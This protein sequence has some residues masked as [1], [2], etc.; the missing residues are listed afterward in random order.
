MVA[1]VSGNSLGLNVTSQATLGSQGLFGSAVGGR[2]NER[3]YVNIANGNLVLQDRDE[4]LLGRGPDADVL[5]TY[6]SEG[7]LLGDT[8]T[9]GATR[10]R[11]YTVA[12]VTGGLLGGLDG[13]TNPATPIVRVDEDGAEAIYAWDKERQLFLSTDGSGAYDTIVYDNVAKQFIWTDGAT[14]VQERY[15]G[16]LASL[17]GA[18]LQSVADTNG[19]V[20]RYFYNKNKLL[21]AILNG[22]LARVET[23]SG[24]NLYFDYND[25]GQITQIRKA[26][27]D[28]AGT[29]DLTKVRYTYDNWKRLSTV[30]VDLSPDDSSIADGRIYKT[31]YTYDGASSR[32]ASITQSDGTTVKFTYVVAGGA[33]RVASVTDGLGQ[34]T[35]Y[36]YDIRSRVTTVTDPLGIQTKYAYDTAGQLTSMTSPAAGGVSQAKHFEYNENGDLLRVTD[37]EGHV[38]LMEYDSWGNQIVQR[39]SLGNTVTRTYDGHHQ[40]LTETAYLVPDADGAG[41]E[42][43]PGMPMTTRYVYDGDGRNL[44]RFVMSPEGRVT[45][46]RYNAFGQRTATL[47]YD[48]AHYPIGSL[49]GLQVPTEAEMQ[50]WLGGIDLAQAIRADTTYDFRGQIDTLTTYVSLDAQGNGVVDAGLA[51]THYVYDHAGQLLQTIA[52]DGGVTYFVYDGLGR[53][54]ATTDAL[55]HVTVTQFDDANNKTVVTLVNG[56]AT[57]SSYDKAGRLVSVMQANPAGQALGITQYF[58]DADN[59]L[60]MSQDP[61]GVRHWKVYDEIGR[62]VGDVD[63]NGTLTETIYNKND[64]ITQTITY[65]TAVNVALLVNAQGVPQKVALA[66][67]RPATSTGDRKSWRAYDAANRLAKE[68]DVDGLLTEYHYDGASR[69]TETIR[70]ATAIDTSP[71]G[72]A[73]SAGSIVATATAQD[74]VARNFYDDDG[75]LRATLDAE[76]Y[77]VELRYDAAGKVVERIAYATATDPALRA[78]GTFEQLVPVG[79]ANDIH[80]HTLYNARGQISGEVDGESTLTEKIYDANGSLAQ[81]IQYANRV[82]SSAAQ[83]GISVAALRPAASAEDQVQYWNHD[84]LG[85]I[86]SYTDATGTRTAYSYDAVGNLTATT[87]AIGT[88]EVRTLTQR[89]DLQ[90]RLTGELSG[91]GSAL[92]NGGQTSA[93]IDVIWARHGMTHTYDAAGRRTGSTDANGN[94]TLFFYDVDGNLTHT[95]NALGEVEARQYNSFNQVTTTTRH[96]TRLA[97]SVLGTMTGGLLTPQAEQDFANLANAALDSTVTMTYHADG[98][99]ASTTDAAGHTI[100]H[101]YDIFNGEALR[102]ETIDGTGATLQISSTRDRRGLATAVTTTSNGAAPALPFVTRSEYDAFGRITRTVDAQGNVRLQQYDRTGRIVQTTDP[103]NGIRTTS[104]D[105]FGRVLTQTDA[106][107]NATQYRYDTSARSFTVTTAEGVAVTTVRNRHGQTASVTDGNGNTT[108]YRYDKNGNL[109]ATASPVSATASVYDGA[110]RLIESI[111]GNGN[112]IGYAYDAANRLLTRTVDPTG[113]ALVTH[114][115][116]DAKGQKIE[117][118]DPNGVVTQTEFDRGGRVLRQTVDPTGLALST[119]YTH[120]ERGNTLTVT[121]PGGTVTRHVYDDLG[122]RIEEH[123]DATGLD[124]I[125]RY[126]YDTLGNLVGAIDAAGNLTRYAYDADNRLIFTV[127]AL[128]QVQQNVYD[129]EG[130]IVRTT[131]YA[132]ALD[133]AALPSAPS[134]AEIQSRLATS[135]NDAVEYRVLDRDGRLQYSVDGMGGVAQYRYDGAG[136]LTERIGYANWINLS[137]WTPGTTP[138]PITDAAR[139]LHERTVYDG[140]NRAIYTVD[141][142]GSVVRQRYDGNGNVVE[143]IAYAHAIPQGTPATAAGFDAATASIA[144]G[145]RDAHIRR[146]YDAANRLTWSM[147]GAGSVTQQVYDRNGNILKQIAYATAVGQNATPDSAVASAG[148]RVTETVY[149][150]VNRAIF[151]IDAQGGVSRTAFDN[152][153]NVL[154]R[155]AYSTP[156]DVPT[157]ASAPRSLNG[158]MSSV[159]ASDDDRVVY[160][161][162]DSASRPTFKI[163]NGNVTET[164]YDAL[165]NALTTIAYS[166]PVTLA[167]T[168]GGVGAPSVDTV[169]AGLQPDPANDRMVQRLFDANSRQTMSVDPLGVATQTRYDGIG[170]VVASTTYANPL[171]AG[172]AP[173]ATAI[174]GALQADPAQDRTNTFAYDAASRLISST[175]ALGYTEHYDYNG[176]GQKTSFTNKKG[177]TWTYTYD[178]AGRLSVETAPLSAMYRAGMSDGKLV[179]D[180]A[181][182]VTANLVTR[183]QYDALGNL[184]ARTEAEGRP[185]VRTTRYEYDAVGRQIRTIYPAVFVYN[186]GADSLAVNGASGLAT[187]TENYVELYS[188]VW[189]D[190]LGN[191]I[192][193][194]DVAGNMQYKAYDVLGRVAYDVDAEGYVTGY[195][196][197][198]FGEVTELTRYAA[199]TTLNGGSLPSRG[200][201]ANVLAGVAHNADRTIRTTYDNLGRAIEVRE[202]ETFVFDGMSGF[203]AGKVTR[204][205]FNAF[206]NVVKQSVLQNPITDSWAT[207]RYLHDQR[208]QKTSTIDAL[209][210]VTE[211]AYDSTG[212]VVSHVE[213]ANAAPDWT[214]TGF[215]QPAQSEDDRITRY[216]YDRNN[217]RITETRVDVEHAEHVGADMTRSDLTTT[218]AYDALGNVTRTI[219]PNGATTYTYYDALGRVSAVVTPEQKS[220]IDGGTRMPLTEFLRDAHG[221]ITAQVQYSDGVQGADPDH[222]IRPNSF[223]GNRMTVYSYD[224]HGHV[225]QSTDAT[226][227][228]QNF[229]YDARGNLA[230]QWQAVTGNDGITR[231]KY[232]AFVYDR[233]GQLTRT[234]TPASNAILTQGLDVA[235]E[236]VYETDENGNV[237]LDESGSGTVTGYNST[238]SWDRLINASGGQVRITLDTMAPMLDESGATVLRPSVTTQT[239][240]PDDVLTSATIAHAGDITAIKIEQQDASGYWV[241]RW[242]G[243]P[244]NFGG[245]NIATVTQDQVGST[246][247]S[248]AYNAFGEVVYQGVDGDWAEYLQYDNAGRLWRTNS[249]DGMDKVALYNLAGEVTADI[250][251]ASVDLKTLSNPQSAEALTGTRRVDTKRDLLGRVIEQVQAERNGARPVLQ[252]K[253]DRW[254]NVLEINDPRSPYW[255]TVYRYN[256]N[257]Q[258]VEV[259]RPDADGAQSASSPVERTYYDTVGNVVA[260]KDANG[261]VNSMLRDAAGNVMVE[262][263]ADTGF[264]RHAYDAFGN[265]IQMMDPHG[266]VTSYSYDGADRLIAVAT[267]AVDVYGV[268]VEKHYDRSLLQLD[269]SDI[270]LFPNFG[271]YLLNQIVEGKYP[272]NVYHKGKASLVTSYAYDQAGNLLHQTNG[273]GETTRFEYDLRGNLTG[274]TQPLGQSVRNIYDAR[275]RKVVE[276]DGNYHAATW[277]Y[278]AFGQLQS[279]MDLGGAT[280]QYTYDRARQLL[281][282]SNS[283]GQSLSYVYDNAGQVT[284]IHDHALGQRTDYMYDLAGNHIYERMEQGGALYQDTIIAYDALNR[285]RQINTADGI[286][287]RVAYDGNGNR[288]RQD[289]RR[290]DGQSQSFFYA[291]DSM[292]RQTLVDGALNNDAADLRNLNS[293]QGHVLTYD[294]NGNRTSD[295][296]WGNQVVAIG[297]DRI[298]R[299]YTTGAYDESGFPVYARNPDGSLLMDPLIDDQGRPYMVATDESGNATVVYLT[300]VTTTTAVDYQQRSGVTTEYYSY[301]A[302]NRLVAIDNTAY[303]RDGN[304]LPQGYG[305]RLD[306]RMYDGANRVVRTGASGLE[307]AYVDKLT[308]GKIANGSESRVNLYDA[309]GR[310][311]QQAVYEADGER[312]Y[313]LFYTDYDGAGNVEHY[314][315]RTH[316]EDAYTA[317]YDYTQVRYDG[318]KEAT[319]DGVRTDNQDDPGASYSQYDAN[320]TL[321]ALKDARKPE[322]DRTFVNDVNGIVIQKQ[323]QGNILKQLVVN[324]QVHAQYGVGTDP[325]KP[326]TDEGDPNYVPQ[327]DYNLN[328]API[329]ANYPTAS[330]GSY[331]VKAGDSLESIAQQAY[332]DAKLWYWIAE[333][334]G[335]SG[336][337]DLKVGQTLSLPNRTGTVHNSHTDFKPYDP[338]KIVGD[339]TPYLPAPSAGGG[340]CGGF[341]MIL[342]I[343]VAIVVSVFTGPLIIGAL[344]STLGTVGATIVGGALAAAAGSIVSQGVGMAIGVQSQFSWKSVAIA[345]ISAGITAGVGGVNFTGGAMDSLGNT[346]IRAAVTNA[347]TQ[348]IAVVT[349]LQDHF[350]WT[351]VA[352]AAVGAG[353]GHVAGEKLGE[354]MSGPQGMSFGDKLLAR[355]ITGL[356]AGTATALMRGGRVSVVQVATDAFGNALGSSLGD[357][358]VAAY[359]SDQQDVLGARIEELRRS[360]IWNDPQP[361]FAGTASTSNSNRGE[362]QLLGLSSSEQAAERA[363]QRGNA[364]LY[365][366]GI[367]PGGGDIENEIPP[368]WK[369]AGQTNSRR[370]VDLGEL[371]TV[372]VTPSNSLDIS[373]VETPHGA[374]GSIRALSDAEAYFSMDSVGRGFRGVADG[375]YNLGAGLLT[376]AQESFRAAGDSI[377]YS[378]TAI[379]N[380]ITGSEVDYEP[381]STLFRSIEKDGMLSTAGRFVT[382]A[383]KGIFAP[384]DALYRQDSYALG[385]SLPGLVLSAGGLRGVSAAGANNVVPH[386]FASADE[387]AQFG[388]NIRA[389][390]GR[391]GYENAEPILQGSAVTGK[392][393][394]T[395]QPFDVGR[396][397]DF[398]V[399]LADPSLLARAQELGIGLRS[400][401]TRTGPLTARDLRALGLRDL[402]NQMGRQVDREVNFMIYK[403]TATAIQKAPSVIFP[404]GK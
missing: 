134:I 92:L 75:L 291:Y 1:I 96:G 401:G 49:A 81:T 24:E 190:A 266:N 314:I 86:T 43:Q 216:T 210:Y 192:A 37:G 16:G 171:P 325:A 362:D 271:T 85:R 127:D 368:Y 308:G 319:I 255:R 115:Q 99:V 265:R 277:Q 302:V 379:G 31:T 3:T 268:T 383:V 124:L 203:T 240:S 395:D 182:A 82:A 179:V 207:T 143:R 145:G 330:P 119:I 2:N 387:F 176:L 342:V 235:S 222:Y 404:G 402:S 41:V 292:N 103:L 267:A 344:T 346:V 320:G 231:T 191:A 80:A 131:E 149:D 391:A 384:V 42:T 318:Y 193:N 160:T 114:Y 117:Q 36:S 248:K 385:A 89:Y 140:G 39:D 263:H 399:G 335:L 219:A 47:Q 253:L 26:V 296:R 269:G 214:D 98:A 389:G 322:N 23:A 70:Y 300:P 357:E 313:G 392:S 59:R 261:N 151:Q 20:I 118:T 107:G 306:T 326:S 339:T 135:A 375:V 142:M 234:I 150:T 403:D 185:E 61:T 35:R 167:G 72:G 166:Q 272:P 121:S 8:W 259:R 378:T 11:L 295:T 77:L 204:T 238:I 125:R 276:V 22:S 262:I 79:S 7:K 329:T 56:L 105:A 159:T 165:G 356:A 380:A 198:R 194:R 293:D 369:N 32:V 202:P 288:L 382:G 354:I 254:G 78:A 123:N 14:G 298:L 64:Q 146:A 48:V 373:L 186:P 177:S 54:I 155:I 15:E 53:I 278:D 10:K 189:Y 108:T 97:A 215:T 241:V 122:R 282:Q 158:L 168:L 297:G 195:Q 46:Y 83:P 21:P 370:I 69:I 63:A 12:G 6:N 239:F 273:N 101:Q 372:V 358:A 93:E 73:P 208:G 18:Q 163:D 102:S 225:L 247:S 175:D 111:D 236:P 229:S 270:T 244:D 60:I 304:A 87:R 141:G 331:T 341:G 286:E 100:S 44:L 197:N 309:N 345:G 201:I 4:L 279:H 332:G 337:S 51:V 71:L 396:V 116:Y 84:L 343:I 184:I 187:R 301:D 274:T 88:A 144:D 38:V 126:Q 227:A 257:N 57:T 161:A 246:E 376:S 283:R 312:K 129:A 174:S 243:A 128:G 394:K 334:N 173:T 321:V 315:M 25:R 5:R 393:F 181:N 311:E 317:E 62:L 355:S 250:R 386:G 310:I 196:R 55:S 264:V 280:Y 169:R 233:L 104:Y 249:G 9:I 28:G 237:I 120:D 153:G 95:V 178:A 50:A 256:V 211:E 359:N 316:G 275:N 188:Q 206:G 138:Q 112:R 110:D 162:Y 17:L 157:A 307:Q 245:H 242:Q 180:Y 148:D 34:V 328:F 200:D 172:T 353:V 224:A 147:D 303:D 30:T 221:N 260:T 223:A 352:A 183:L 289:F 113:L 360:P 164:R 365:A 94:R 209:G 137:A 258:V 170:R 139:D 397:S 336:N 371:P 212:N 217:R 324:G 400:G 251:S 350:S 281:T 347:A 40:L 205:T 348:G 290:A 381:G 226:G 232:T 299:G 13:V 333:A 338:S 361:A 366:K 398:D 65:A 294:L 130:R 340:G 252:Q 351:G 364:D 154:A 74:R 19:N 323:Q 374:M 327:N 58:Y 377:G 90:G 199:Q 45:E 136:N 367:V 133:V 284:Q 285:V 27:T 52:P 67:L 363:F 156:L 228:S 33:A 390:L 132:Q 220:G 305:I 91:E 287:M 68:I 29:R 109:V 152:N 230:K 388:N 218:Y 66:S 213:Y 349:G 106:L 76:G